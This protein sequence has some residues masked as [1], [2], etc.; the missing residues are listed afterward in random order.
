MTRFVKAMLAALLLTLPAMAMAHTALRSS[1]PASG[2][3]LTRS[4]SALTLTFIEPTRLTSL[5]LVSSA[6]ER[7]LPF[8]AAG[9]LTYTAPQPRFA[10]G[11]NEVRWRALSR[12]GHVVEGRIIIVL[13]A[14]AR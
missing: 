10:P 9:P 2:S 3:V 7:A 5:N 11:R 13:R 4:P 1:S 14:P 6:G 8:S 12:D